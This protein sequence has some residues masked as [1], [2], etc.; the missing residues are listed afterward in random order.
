MY[1]DYS[2]LLE[3]LTGEVDGFKIDSEAVENY[4]GELTEL[5]LASLC[6]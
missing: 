2:T 5:L 4:E 3:A 6:G 1:N